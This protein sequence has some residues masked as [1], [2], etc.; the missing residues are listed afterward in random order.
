[1]EGKIGAICV[2]CGGNRPLSLFRIKSTDGSFSAQVKCQ[3]SI[4]G[5]PDKISF[6]DEFLLG[7]MW[8]GETGKV[9]K[10]SIVEIHVYYI[11]FMHKKFPLS[12]RGHGVVEVDVAVCNFR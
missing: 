7:A 12:V 10:E 8:D 6:D 11:P 9:P 2:I 5:E 3:N 4:E 1:L